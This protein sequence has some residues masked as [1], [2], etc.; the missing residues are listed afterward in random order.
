MTDI[1]KIVVR[2]S[3]QLSL[4]FNSAALLKRQEPQNKHCQRPRVPKIQGG[5]ASEK[6]QLVVKEAKRKTSGIVFALIICFSVAQPPRH[7]RGIVFRD[8]QKSFKGPG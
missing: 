7:P 2:T 8:K 6:K 3:Q 1:K 5:S 4:H